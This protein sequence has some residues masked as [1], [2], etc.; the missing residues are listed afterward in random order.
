MDARTSITINIR[1]GKS[2]DFRFLLS[3]DPGCFEG[4][5]YGLGEANH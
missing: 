3:Y 4:R 2:S 5:V 1:S